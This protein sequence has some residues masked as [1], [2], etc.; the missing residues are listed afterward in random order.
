MNVREPE[1]EISARSRFECHNGTVINI[2]ERI[3]V[4]DDTAFVVNAPLKWEVTLPR[5]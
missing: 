3:Q 1:I 4:E 2:N 5:Q